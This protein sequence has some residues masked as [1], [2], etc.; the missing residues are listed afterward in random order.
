M[1]LHI[2]RIPHSPSSTRGDVFP[3]VAGRD[4]REASRPPRSAAQGVKHLRLA[5]VVPSAVAT[6]TVDIRVPHDKGGSYR[7]SVTSE[8][9]PVTRQTARLVTHT[10]REPRVT[11]SA[12]HTVAPVVALRIYARQREVKPMARVTPITARNVE[13]LMDIQDAFHELA[14]A[15]GEV[16]A[17][18]LELMALINRA[19]VKAERIDRT[20]RIARNVEDSGELTPWVLR[21][22][23]EMEADL[24]NLVSIEDY[25]HANQP[26]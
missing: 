9:T 22:A 14:N 5:H 12:T 16:C 24:G 3:R 19:V 4:G 8:Y 10:A 7:P 1:T 23:R 21:N 25:R 26:A 13:L 2:L 18:E 15:D 17:S 20:R 6:A 11:S